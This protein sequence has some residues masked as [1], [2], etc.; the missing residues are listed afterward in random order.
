M[1]GR[2]NVFADIGRQA[3]EIIGKQLKVGNDLEWAQRI[4]CIRACKRDDGEENHLLN[5]Q[6]RKQKEISAIFTLT[7]I[8]K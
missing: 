1:S 4:N 6:I 8:C 3:Q 7:R 2:L 5:R